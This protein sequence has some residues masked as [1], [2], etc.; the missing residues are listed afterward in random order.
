MCLFFSQCNNISYFINLIRILKTPHT[1]PTYTTVITRPLRATPLT[2]E[3][4]FILTKKKQATC[5]IIQAGWLPLLEKD[6]TDN[7]FEQIESP[8]QRMLFAQLNCLPCRSGVIRDYTSSGIPRFQYGVRSD[9]PPP[10]SNQKSGG[11]S[12]RSLRLVL[13][14]TIIKMSS[15]NVFSLFHYY[16]Y[17]PSL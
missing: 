11:Q 7:P 6:C 4:Y 2:R 3:T 5:I 14:K 10:T 9:S 12:Q 17:L 15:M 13:E 8:Y 16:M 1:P